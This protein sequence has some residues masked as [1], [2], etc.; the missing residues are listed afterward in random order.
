MDAA[1][2][3]HLHTVEQRL[4]NGVQHIG[5]AHEEDLGHIDRHIQV[6]VQEAVVLLR[7][8]QLQQGTGRVPLVTC[9]GRGI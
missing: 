6:V 7:V 2:D 8:Q 9:G 3:A 1:G 4:G 5:G